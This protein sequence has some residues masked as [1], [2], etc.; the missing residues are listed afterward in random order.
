METYVITNSDLRSLSFVPVIR[1]LIEK[2]SE[3]NL[4]AL[5]EEDPRKWHLLLADI[6]IEVGSDLKQSTEHPK[7]P[8]LPST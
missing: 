5:I 1:N 4:R 2:R 3:D 7:N 6:L 8:L